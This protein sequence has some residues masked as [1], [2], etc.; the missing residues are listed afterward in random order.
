M[1]DD[2]FVRALLGGSLVAAVAG[3]LGAFVV[4][5]R[6][7]YFGSMLAHS[8]LLGVV[9]GIMLGTA[10]MLGVFGLCLGLAA[11]VLLAEERIGLPLDTLLG[12]LAHGALALGLVALSF[13]ETV[14]VDLMAYLFGD[15]LAVSLP[16]LLLI[17]GLGATILA[18]LAWHRRG[19]IAMT[20]DE[21]VARVEGVPVR[22][23]RAILMLMLGV[24]IAFGLKI[25]GVLLIV[26]LLIIP[27]AAARPLARTPEA[28]MA[29]A[30]ALGV[31]AVLGGLYASLE[32]DLPAGPAIV[33]VAL[34]LFMASHAARRV[35]VRA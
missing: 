8:A 2:F 12:I 29:I 9:L 32:F 11:L 1:I 16:D 15:V 7:A 33:A 28:M 4:W 27:A 10:P 18:L 22:R 34:C 24:L 14:R 35:S 20:V 30:A 5:R 3:P 21:R 13:V 6:M 19:L 26:S 17:A 31:A 25:V 23:L